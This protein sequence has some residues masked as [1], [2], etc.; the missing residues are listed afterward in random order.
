MFCFGNVTKIF[1]L[2]LC[3]VLRIRLWA[4]VGDL[5]DFFGFSYRCF[6]LNAIFLNFLIII[7]FFFNV[8]GFW[9]YAISSYLYPFCVFGSGHKLHCNAALMNNSFS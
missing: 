3:Y 8:V 7:C 4:D 1:L 2:L 6:D 5:R 9:F